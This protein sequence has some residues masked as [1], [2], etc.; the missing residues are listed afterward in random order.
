MIRRSWFRWIWVRIKTGIG[1]VDLFWFWGARG[2]D[3]EGGGER[4]VVSLWWWWRWWWGVM[5]VVVGMSGVSGTGHE[6]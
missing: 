2:V 6:E 3:L 1:E 4:L 5:M